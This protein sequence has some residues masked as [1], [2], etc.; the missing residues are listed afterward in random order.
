MD[1]LK[2]DTHAD[3]DRALDDLGRELQRK[4]QDLK[5]IE[6]DI[7]DLDKLAAALH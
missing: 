2:R 5:Q 7:R 3:I 4:N 1:V 6:Y